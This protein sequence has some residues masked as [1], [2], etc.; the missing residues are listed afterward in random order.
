MKIIY[1][2]FKHKVTSTLKLLKLLCDNVYISKTFLFFRNDRQNS[3]TSRFSR[4][5]LFVKLLELIFFPDF[6]LMIL[7][8]DILVSLCLFWPFCP[9]LL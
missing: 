1:S 9:L 3:F 5:T 7:L 6:E 4:L 2:T 8:L